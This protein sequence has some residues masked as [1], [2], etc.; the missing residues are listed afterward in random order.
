L[1]HIYRNNPGLQDQT[2]GGISWINAED[3]E[4]G[5][6]SFHRR[7]GGQQFACIFNTYNKDLHDYWLPLPDSSYAPELDRLVRIREIYNTD[8]IA[9]GGLGRKNA[10]VGTI[11]NFSTYRPTHLKLRLPPFTALVLEECFS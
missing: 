2:N 11:R 5:V 4:N 3:A 10:H 6:L 7:G 9:F 8:E 1:L